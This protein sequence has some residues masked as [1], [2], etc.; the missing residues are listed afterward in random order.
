MG[1]AEGHRVVVAVG[2]EARVGKTLAYNVDV[3]ER[4]A[5]ALLTAASCAMDSLFRGPF[6]GALD[7]L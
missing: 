2:S 7:T 1:E 3:A 6:L 4:S 5:R